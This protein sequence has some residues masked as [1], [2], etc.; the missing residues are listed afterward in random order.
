M[1]V[2]IDTPIR[3]GAQHPLAASSE[4][5]RHILRRDPCA[6]CGRRSDTVD[7]IISLATGGKDADNLTG[8]CWQCNNVKGKEPLLHFL[9][10]IRWVVA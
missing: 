4:P 7:H 8:A 3:W 9:R 5:W 6:Y 2:L 10:R 1:T